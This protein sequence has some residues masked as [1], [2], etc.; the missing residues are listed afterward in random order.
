MTKRVTLAG[1]IAEHEPTKDRFAEFAPDWPSEDELR[2][3]DMAVHMVELERADGNL[4]HAYYYKNTTV[5][6][7]LCKALERV[8]KIDRTFEAQMELVHELEKKILYHEREKGKLASGL[9][10]IV[11]SMDKKDNGQRAKKIA[12][13]TLGNLWDD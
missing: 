3:R 7:A 5:F 9:R 10:K 11:R 6:V 8:V 13:E 12:L 4:Q 2:V 1:I